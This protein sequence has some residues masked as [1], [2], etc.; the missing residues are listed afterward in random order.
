MY[1]QLDDWMND[2]TN[3]RMMDGQVNEWTTYE[4]INEGM[5]E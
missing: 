3:D 1:D 5:D 2:W 4:K